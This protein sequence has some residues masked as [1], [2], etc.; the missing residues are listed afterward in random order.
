M[1]KT[2]KQTALPPRWL[3][4]AIQSVRMA[5][6]ALHKRMFPATAVLYEQF[7]YL[8]LLP[9]LYVA[10]ELDIA[11]KLRSGS[12]TADELATESKVDPEGLYRVLRALSGNGIF[13]ETANRRFALTPL[14]RPLTN[15]PG[16]L[17]YMLIHHLSPVNWQ[18]V[19]D[20][21]ETVR[22]GKDG[23]NRQY[24]RNIYEYLSAHPAAFGIFDKSMSALSS[25]GLA[26][27]FQVYNFSGI[28]LLADIG[29]GEGFFLAH[30]LAKNS[31]MRGILYD[32]PEALSKAEETLN[33][34]GV[35]NRVELMEGDFRKTVPP[36]ADGYLL[37]NV[38]HNWDDATCID[39]L[40]NIREA[41]P[42]NGRVILIDMVIPSG[43]RF[44]SSKMIDI[45]MLA[46]MPGGKERTRKEFEAILRETGLKLHRF[47][48]TIAPVCVLEARRIS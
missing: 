23:F 40:S 22:T 45:Q 27:V 39:I 44:S 46:S 31:G 43:S 47:Y 38:L 34:C 37:K 10:A 9:S 20:L 3:V 12:K 7:Q 26:P 6:L 25:L 48:P 24:G 36:G 33:L 2:S 29:G 18:I 5:L 42:A 14:A 35:G 13:K 32:L 28:R 30:I 15:E 19:G 11:E 21:L 16:S 41:M 1:K 8:Y 17:R 4:N